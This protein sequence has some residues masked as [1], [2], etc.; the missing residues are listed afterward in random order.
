MPYRWPVGD[1][2]YELVAVS[3]HSRGQLELM[4]AGL[5]LDVPIVVVDN[6]SGADRIDELLQDR[7]RARYLD[8]GGGKGFAVAGN[9]GV[10]SSTA[11]FCVFV[12]PD[13]RPTV[14][15]V[16][17]LLRRL[18]S[19]PRAGT[20]SAATMEAGGRLELG[21][22]GWEP[23]VPRVIVNALALHKLL[24]KAGIFARPRP[25]EPIRLDWTNGACMA[26]SRERFLT[27]GG[28]VEDYF[29]YN[30]DMAFG[31]TLREAG[32]EAVLC[33]DLMVPHAAGTSGGSSAV[34][35]QLRG[36]SMSDYLRDYHPGWR[37]RAMRAVLLGGTQFRVALNRARRNP[38]RA[39]LFSSYAAG[40]TQ[41]RPDL[42]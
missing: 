30:E 11:D 4:L 20:V 24:P 9:M 39:L 14:E 13:S 17:E 16:D 7:P 23:S 34:M 18:T 8:S 35:W 22:G 40:I 26:V 25:N 19:N 29:V 37:A 38:D 33:T 28:F 41:G 12:N 36:A 42:S 27:M 1:F 5:P 6:A 21:V 32:L 3:Y 31:R 2:S 15:I 10:K